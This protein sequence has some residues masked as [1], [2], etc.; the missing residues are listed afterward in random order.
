MVRRILKI[1]SDNK[2]ITLND[3]ISKLKIFFM[4]FN[5][6]GEFEIETT[7]C[8]DRKKH[9][10]VEYSEW[11]EYSESLEYYA[12]TT[13][14]IKKSDRLNLLEFLWER[15]QITLKPSGKHNIPAPFE[16][17]KRRNIAAL[18]VF[19]RHPDICNSKYISCVG[20]TVK[21][22]KEI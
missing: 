9:Q 22:L 5:L 19:L 21:K 14:R 15:G 13:Y 6:G 16:L 18:R 2:K 1:L 3:T 20:I 12:A 4:L 7:R 17:I 10:W 11:I 8:L